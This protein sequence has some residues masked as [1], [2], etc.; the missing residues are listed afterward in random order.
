MPIKYYKV[1]QRILVTWNINV[2][3]DILMLSEG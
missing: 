2:N 3:G 1:I